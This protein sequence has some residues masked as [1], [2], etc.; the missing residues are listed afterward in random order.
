MGKRLSKRIQKK[1]NEFKGTKGVIYVNKPK[2]FTEQRKAKAFR[3]LKKT[4]VAEG[5]ILGGMLGGG[6]VGAARGVGF[7]AGV[8]SSVAG[9]GSY[10]GKIAKS[11]LPKTFKGTLKTV[12]LG[13]VGAGVL[14]TSKKAR[15]YVKGKLRPYKKGEELGEVIEGE[16]TFWDFLGIRPREPRPPKTPDDTNLWKNIALALGGL[17]LGA[18]AGVAG[19][20][21]YNYFQDQKENIPLSNDLIPYSF[22]PGVSGSSTMTPYTPI[23][24]SVE[25]ITTPIEQNNVYKPRRRTKKKERNINVTQNV[26]VRVNA[27]NR[28]I[29]KQ[30]LIKF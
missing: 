2:E 25:D 29:Y 30:K 23:S 18:G 26:N 13:L 20:S 24:Q 10:L 8:R 19:T 5:L 15:Q 4:A 17:G 14:T 21:A 9:A 28:K 3:I 1:I 11:A 12:G 22:G 16:R 27:G 7:S 6:A